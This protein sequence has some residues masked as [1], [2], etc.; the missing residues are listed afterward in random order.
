MQTTDSPT[1]E[2][3]VDLIRR[4]SVTPDDAGCQE[5]MMSRLAPLGFTGENLRFGDTDNLWARKGSE[6]PV[7]AFAGHTDVVPT[8]KELVAPTL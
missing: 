7:L 4:P 5:L 6:G 1:L 3:A 8:G 2:L